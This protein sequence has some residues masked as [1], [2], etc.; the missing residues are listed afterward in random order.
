MKGE[1]N[2]GKRR[3][4]ATRFSYRTLGSLTMSNTKKIGINAQ[5]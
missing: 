2:G 5:F 1:W 4:D 3:E